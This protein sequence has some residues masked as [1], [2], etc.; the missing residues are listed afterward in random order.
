ML[1]RGPLAYGDLGLIWKW[2]IHEQKLTHSFIS[3]VL[4]I[5]QALGLYPANRPVA[6]AW[7]PC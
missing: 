2:N 4:Q 7:A 3:I 6:L 1:K 5:Q